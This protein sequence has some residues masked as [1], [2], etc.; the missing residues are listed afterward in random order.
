[1]GV[2]KKALLVKY[3]RRLNQAKSELRYA[4]NNVEWCEKQIAELK[5]ENK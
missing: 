4:M 2:S 1:V 5:G 3:E